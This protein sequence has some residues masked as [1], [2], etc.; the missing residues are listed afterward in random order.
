MT[1]IVDDLSQFFSTPPRMGICDL[2]D[3]RLESIYAEA[4]CEKAYGM[5]PVGWRKSKGINQVDAHWI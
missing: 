5:S 3:T 1:N 4:D 2:V